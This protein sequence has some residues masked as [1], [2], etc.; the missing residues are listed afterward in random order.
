MLQKTVIKNN[1]KFNSWEI[2][3]KQDKPSESDRCYGEVVDRLR[4]GDLEQVVPGERVLVTVL[5]QI[6]VPEVM[7]YS[8]RLV[9]TRP[10]TDGGAKRL[11]SE[12]KR[13]YFRGP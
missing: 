2:N 13:V 4:D 10:E 8:Q 3:I 5:T 11:V 12:A 7:I 6:H 9:R 1:G